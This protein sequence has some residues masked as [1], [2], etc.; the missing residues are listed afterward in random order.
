MRVVADA[1]GINRP[2]V[3]GKRKYVKH[4][5]KGRFLGSAAVVL[6]LLLLFAATQ[7]H[8]APAPGSAA[9]RAVAHPVIRLSPSSSTVAPGATFVVNVVVD[10]VVDL[11]GLDFALTFNPAVVHVQSVALGSFLASTGRSVI[12]VGPAI[13]NTAG[14]VE[15][16]AGSYDPTGTAISGPN[17]TGTLAQVTLQAVAVGSSALTFVHAP[18]EFHTQLTGT[19]LY[20]DLLTVTYPTLNSGS[21]TVAQG[22]LLGDVNA[23]GLANSTDALI[24]LS[25]DAGFNT[26]AFCP[27]NCGDTNADGYVNSTDALII[28]SYD[29]AMTVPFPVGQP[30][31]PASVTPCAGCN[32]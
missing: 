19:E 10:N 11:G 2:A 26:A 6:C 31:C 3:V 25:C 14:I 30:G 7:V 29:A 4:V 12:A 8:A 22:G 17:G 20:P 27:M 16:G 24:V 9:V 1:T 32:P 15:F 18:L 13:D 5:M 28:L 21:V 23:D